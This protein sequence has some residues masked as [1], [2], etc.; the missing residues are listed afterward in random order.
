MPDIDVSAEPA[1]SC[2]ICGDRPGRGRAGRRRDAL[3]GRPSRYLTVQHG[4]TPDTGGVRGI[5]PLPAGQYDVGAVLTGFDAGRITVTVSAAMTSAAPVPLLIHVGATAPGCGLS[6]SLP[7]AR[8][9]SS[10]SL[11]TGVAT[12]ARRAMRATARAGATWTPTPA[13]RRLRRCRPGA[14]P[15]RRGATTARRPR[16]LA[17]TAECRKTR[18][19]APATAPMVAPPTRTVPP[20]ASSA[21]KGAARHWRAATAG[22]RRC[23]AVCY[24]DSRCASYLAG[25]RCSGDHDGLPGTCTAPCAVDGDCAVGSVTSFVCAPVPGGEMPLGCVPG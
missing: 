20:P 23:R 1:G 18:P 5:W 3:S 25:G 14:R 13:T 10:A 19:P 9:G 11:P 2:R 12:S 7:R 17:C 4:I 16:C 6:P 15:A 24:S 21:T 8:T 22:S